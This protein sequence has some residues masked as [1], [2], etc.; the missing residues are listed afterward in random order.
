MHGRCL[1]GGRR[2][3]PP[4]FFAWPLNIP[5]FPRQDGCKGMPWAL[6]VLRWLQHLLPLC[7]AGACHPDVAWGVTYTCPG[8]GLLASLQE[9]DTFP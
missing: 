7:G 9:S 4:G 6:S 1:P 3:I 5:F 2:L 8:I